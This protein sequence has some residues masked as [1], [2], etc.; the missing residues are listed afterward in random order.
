MDQ[1]APSAGIG[2]LPLY[3]ANCDNL[4][5]HDH[6]DY[7]RRGWTR[8]ERT[9]FAAFNMLFIL[10]NLGHCPLEDIGHLFGWRKRDS[11][12]EKC[13]DDCPRVLIQS[14]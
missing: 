7:Q 8:V 12:G 11:F 3:L 5:Y 2:M 10:H 1:R 14:V 13:I 9:V 4:V 6:Q